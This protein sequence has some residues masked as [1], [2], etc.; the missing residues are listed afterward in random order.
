[1]SVPEAGQSTGRDEQERDAY[2]Q[3]QTR[4]LAALMQGFCAARYRKADNTPCPID[5]GLYLGSVGAAL[6]KDALK[7]LNIT[8]V[9]VVARSLNPAFPAEFTYKKIEVLDSPD[10]DLVK[11][12][13]E[14]FAF[15]DEG[16][17]TGGNVLVHCFAGRS[18]SVTVVLA[19]LMNKHQMSLQSAMSLV[20]S[21]RAQI[22][23]NEGFMSQL[24]N[25]EKSLQA[26]EQG[27]R[28]MQSN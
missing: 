19:Y 24:V 26:V 27:R 4:V 2:E 6:N 16:I 25:F 22:A 14:C 13:G 15:I 28:V 12:F 8:H 21:K 17:C 18:R 11:H 1:M 23:P 3:H 7:S 20:K 9:L 5:Q 10:T